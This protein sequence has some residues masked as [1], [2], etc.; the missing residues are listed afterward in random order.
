M[1]VTVLANFLMFAVLPFS[2]NKSEYIPRTLLPSCLLGKTVE[3]S[4]TSSMVS[5]AGL[6]GPFDEM[7]LD[8]EGSVP[9][10]FFGVLEALDGL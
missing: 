9:Y 1:F 8:R 5:S 6:R 3:I 7:V 10:S 2:H 4:F